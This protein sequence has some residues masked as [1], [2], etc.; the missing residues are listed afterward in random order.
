MSNSVM[1][2]PWE[3]VSSCRTALEG[4]LEKEKKEK[5]WEE[6]K[7]LDELEGMMRFVESSPC[8]LLLPPSS[9]QD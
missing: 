4:L 1:L 8:L 3:K 6:E 2:D 9:A 7:W 5:G